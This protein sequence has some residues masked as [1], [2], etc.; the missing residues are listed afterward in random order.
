MDIGELLLDMAEKLHVSP[1]FLSGVE[2]GKRKIPEGWLTKIADLYG[3]SEEQHE[4]MKEAYYD[5][6][7]EIEI[8]LHNLEANQRDLAIAFARK[9][10]SI[11]ES[12]ISKI[13][14]ILNKEKK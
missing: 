1:A 5:S 2:N 14:N 10:D 8:G 13:M 9:L 11:P 7:N 3:L 12:D 4:K 6:N